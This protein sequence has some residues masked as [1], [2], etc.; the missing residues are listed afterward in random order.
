MDQVVP[1][2]VIERKILLIR[3]QKVMLDEHL[4]EL[5]GVTTKRLN[6]QVKRNLKR[7]PHDFMFRLNA[8]EDKILRSQFAT[9][10]TQR[11]GR[12]YFPFA[13]SICSSMALKIKLDKKLTY[14]LNTNGPV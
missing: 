3:G 1:V 13:F 2:E 12:R 14:K 5:Y 8:E 11:G 10:K 7:F 4:A 6:E 9:S